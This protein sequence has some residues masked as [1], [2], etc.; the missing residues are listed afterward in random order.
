MANEEKK[1]ENQEV[2]AEVKETTENVETNEN[3]QNAKKGA[4]RGKRPFTKRAPKAEV[5]EYEERVVTINRVTKVV[6]GGK[7]MKFSAVVVIGNGKGKYG[8]GSGKS[9]EVPDAIKKAVE[10]AKRNTFNIELANAKSISHEIIGKFGATEVFLKPAP[11]GTG[12]IAGG[13]VRAI[14]ELAGIQ[15]V[16]SK[17][18]GSR[19]PINVIRATHNAL[20]NLK[21][22]K[23][24][25]AL[26]G[27]KEESSDVK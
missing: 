22:Y 8:F 25:K 26:R 7:R 10:K 16:Y 12:I 18:Y 15:N 1:V 27:P 14:L 4:P 21:S 19:T 11:E 5:K 3:A 13:A 9:G 23:G 20:S 17:V 24:V 2:Q 6:S